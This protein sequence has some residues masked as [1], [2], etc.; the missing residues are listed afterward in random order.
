MLTDNNKISLLLQG[1]RQ[2]DR[3]SQKELY[4]LLRGFALKICYRYTSST[5]E[6]EEIMH[7]AFVKLYKNIHQFD[8]FRQSDLLISLKGWFK[9]ILVNT[10]I[11]Q[12]RKKQSSVNGHKMTQ[13]AENIRD[14][15]ESGLDMLSY[16]EIIEAIRTLSPSYRTV[17]N[18]FVIEGLTHEEISRKLGISVGASKSN[19]SK[20]R[21]NLRK[22]LT[23]QSNFKI[24]V[25]PF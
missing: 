13:D 12:F 22:Y 24:Y 4:Y 15:A 9:R 20:A 5:E 16:K 11:D 8:E 7:E 3:N 2:N 23:N 17:F 21:D 19:L 18:L 10:C 25:S 14:V 6:S 1:C